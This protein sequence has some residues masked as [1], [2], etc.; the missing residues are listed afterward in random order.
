MPR[1]QQAFE[2]RVLSHFRTAPLGEAKLLHRLASSA[3]RERTAEGAG[4]SS[5][6]PA[7]NRK[8]AAGSGNS[9]KKKATKK[10]RTP[11]TPP[12]DDELPT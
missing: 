2:E 1:A 12:A 9:G 7:R 6:A 3:L 11:Q 10:K 5:P 4:Q 8:A